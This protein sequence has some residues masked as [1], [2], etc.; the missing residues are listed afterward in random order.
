MKDFQKKFLNGY[1]SEGLTRGAVECFTHR[2]EDVECETLRF[3]ATVSFVCD[4]SGE[5][6]DTVI[7]DW[8]VYDEEGNDVDWLTLEYTDLVGMFFATVEVAEDYL[9]SQNELAVEYQSAEDDY[10]ANMYDGSEDRFYD[11]D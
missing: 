8:K 1:T 2:V 9:P 6:T 3:D 5:I 10:Y 4:R 7:D 11:E